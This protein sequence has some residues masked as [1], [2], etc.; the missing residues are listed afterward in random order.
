[1]KEEGENLRK[2]KKYLIIINIILL[3]P[4]KMLNLSLFEIERKFSSLN[5]ENVINLYRE[6]NG[7]FPHLISRSKIILYKYD[8]LKVDLSKSKNKIFPN[9]HKNMEFTISEKNLYKENS[10]LLY[11]PLVFYENGLKKYHIN[12]LFIP[13]IL[14]LDYRNKIRALLKSKFNGGNYKE[15]YLV[16]L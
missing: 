16:K 8:N 11:S 1:M 6:N 3:I 2:I 4:L 9:R 10:E 7:Q 5:L 13:F 14:F 15:I 12:Q